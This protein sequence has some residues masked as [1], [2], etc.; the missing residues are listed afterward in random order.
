M[1]RS[2]ISEY[3]KRLSKTVAPHTCKGCGRILPKNS[4]MLIWQVWI[5]YRRERFR[6]CSDCQ[7]IIYGC[8]D[9]PALCHQENDLLVRDMCERCD[10]FPLCDKVEYLRTSRPGDLYLG[11]VDGISY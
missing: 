7:R 9:R 10:G 2:V 6:F 11:D 8:E 4:W 5:D 3:G 1:T